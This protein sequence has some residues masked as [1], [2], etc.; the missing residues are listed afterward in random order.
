VA[1]T[2]YWTERALR[3]AERLDRRARERVVAAV[4][5]FAETEHGDI[6]RHRGVEP[7]AWRLRVGH[8]RVVFEF[9]Q[10]TGEVRV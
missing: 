10:A 7:P 6:K 4:E 2:V 8:Y 3:E 1:W 9:V 5:W